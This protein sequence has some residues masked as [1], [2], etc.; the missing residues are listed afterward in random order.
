MKNYEMEC[1]WISAQLNVEMSK[2]N[3]MASQKQILA[4]TPLLNT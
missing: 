4:S 3:D 1:N 2:S